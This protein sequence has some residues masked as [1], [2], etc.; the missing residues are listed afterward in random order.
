MNKFLNENDIKETNYL[1]FV[2]LLSLQIIKDKT[3]IK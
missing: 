2:T 3:F 1:K